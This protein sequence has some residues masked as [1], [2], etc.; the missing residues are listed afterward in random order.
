MKFIV[1]NETFGCSPDEYLFDTFDDAVNE[2]LKCADIHNKNEMR[3]VLE[4]VKR[5]RNADA[6]AEIYSIQNQDTGEV[7][8]FRAFVCWH[9]AYVEDDTGEIIDWQDLMKP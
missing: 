2:V 6:L 7:R 5:Y 1:T 9:F 4:V 3:R 8:K